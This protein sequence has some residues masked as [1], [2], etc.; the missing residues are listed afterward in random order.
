MSLYGH[1]IRFIVIIV[2]A[3]LILNVGNYPVNTGL[4]HD[5]AQSKN[6]M[7]DFTLIDGGQT[8]IIA[9]KASYKAKKACAD[10]LRID[11]SLKMNEYINCCVGFEAL[12]AVHMKMVVFWV[13][14]PC[15]LVEVYH[16]PDDGG[17]KYF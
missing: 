5:A 6:I 2:N 16:R 7:N 11:F 10:Q 14:A 9:L 4:D 1:A 17:R 12:T 8:V 13:V 3:T 15:S